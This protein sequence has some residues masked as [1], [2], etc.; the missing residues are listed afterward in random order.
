[1]LHCTDLVMSID[2]L[3]MFSVACLPLYDEARTRNATQSEKFQNVTGGGLEP[4]AAPSPPGPA[5]SPSTSPREIYKN[6]QPITFVSFSSF[7][8][9]VVMGNPVSEF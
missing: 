9:F 5:P 1:M 2:I 4:P 3:I 7:V 8:S 6:F